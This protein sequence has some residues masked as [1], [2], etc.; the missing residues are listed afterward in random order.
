MTFL[1]KNSPFLLFMLL[2]EEANAAEHYER[3]KFDLYK[4]D[5]CLVLTLTY[6]LM[7]NFLSLF[8][9]ILLFDQWPGE[10]LKC[11][12]IVKALFSL[13]LND[14]EC[15]CSWPPFLFQSSNVHIIKN[16]SSSATHKKLRLYVCPSENLIHL[17][18]D[19]DK[20]NYMNTNIMNTQI[21]HFNKYDLKGHWRS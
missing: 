8:N 11:L 16:V 1:N 20:K 6:V 10:L 12:I 21:F 15:V 17:W 14:G 18:I 19:F 3:T 5:I 9:W 4:D 13:Q 2:I 7:D